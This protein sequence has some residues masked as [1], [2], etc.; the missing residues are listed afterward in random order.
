MYGLRAL[1]IA[2][3]V[4]ITLVA[5]MYVSDGSK[6]MEER[7]RKKKLRRICKDIYINDMPRVGVDEMRT[8]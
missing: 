5:Q 2:C 6:K 7:E 3:I 1:E 4:H 8:S